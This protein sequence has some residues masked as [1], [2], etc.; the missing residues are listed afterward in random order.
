MVKVVI[1]VEVVLQ[2]IMVVVAV[3]E[4]IEHLLIQKHQ[5][6]EVHQNLP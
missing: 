6:E 3:L 1:M 2:E 5:V 4:D